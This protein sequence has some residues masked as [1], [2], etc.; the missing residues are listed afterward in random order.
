MIRYSMITQHELI[1][2]NF[3]SN[4]DILFSISLLPFTYS[5]HITLFCTCIQYNILYNSF[6]YEAA[7]CGGIPI[8]H[9]L[10]SDFLADRITKIRGIM[11]GTVSTCVCLCVWVCVQM[12]VCAL[13]LSVC[14]FGWMDGRLD[15]CT[16]LSL[17]VLVHM[18]I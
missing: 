7:V 11:N 6:N 2:Y 3:T 4:F 18:Y 8:I 16:C 9:S 14:M 12:Y 5:L 10:H 1:Q 17:H 15:G 13:C